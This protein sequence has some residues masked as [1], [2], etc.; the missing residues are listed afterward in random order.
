[1]MRSLVI[2]VFLFCCSATLAQQ[3]CVFLEKG[4]KGA[5][6][7]RPNG[8]VRLRSQLSQQQL[9]PS[10]F[11]EYPN[12][13]ISE[14]FAADQNETSVAIS[15]TDPKRILVG[16]NDYRSFNALWKFLSTDG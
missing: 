1:M 6:A 5:K 13:N 11:G 9:P 15:P 7:R 14:A 16:A 2:F 12:I 3:S 8:L 10:V 4:K